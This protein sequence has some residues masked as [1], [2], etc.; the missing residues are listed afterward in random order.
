MLSARNVCLDNSPVLRDIM[1][2]FGTG[3]IDFLGFLLTSS[4]A[5]P[6]RLSGL[7]FLKRPCMNASGPL[8][9]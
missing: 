5:T 6:L 4:F 9:V 2:D 8:G 1:E 7:K 3:D